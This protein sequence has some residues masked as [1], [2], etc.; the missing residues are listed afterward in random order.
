MKIGILMA[1]DTPEALRSDFPSFSEMF[2]EMISRQIDSPTF[3]VF[4][5][6]DGQFPKDIEACDVWLVTGSVSSAYDGDSWINDL[7][8]LIV[9]IDSKK[10]RLI[11]VCFGHQ[12]IAKAL[13]G[14]VEKYSEG[15]GVGLH[16]YQFCLEGNEPRAEVFLPAFHQDQVVEKPVN[17][18]VLMTS[19]FCINA[20][21]KYGEHVLTCQFHP[22]FTIPFERALIELYANESIP[23][24][25][26][27]EAIASFNKQPDNDVF[28]KLI[29]DF[30][31]Q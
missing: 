12:I 11:G 27:Q 17:A 31:H 20:A 18:K 19:K 14:R 7:E 3:Q 21:L 10:I 26:Y 2:Q 1:G 6:K 22:E 25:V 9:E 13:G 4:S 28:A 24:D 23:S 16:S 30:I 15:W 29:G 8:Q 5:V